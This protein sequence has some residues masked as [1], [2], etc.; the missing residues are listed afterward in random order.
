M[1]IHTTLSV[2]DV[3]KNY[4][5]DHCTY[6]DTKTGLREKQEKKRPVSF[7]LPSISTCPLF[8]KSICLRDK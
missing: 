4:K 7:L 8:S 1:L 2:I 6:L 3:L 5:I